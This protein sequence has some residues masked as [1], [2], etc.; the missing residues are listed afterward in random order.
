M[1]AL[2]AVYAKTAAGLEEVRHRALPLSRT[3]RT[4]LILV[5]GNRRLS[6]LAAALG[7]AGVDPLAAAE[8]LLSHRLIESASGAAPAAQSGAP[9]DVRAALVAA[10][11]DAFGTRAGPV[12]RKL[13]TVGSSQAELLA[14]AEA[15][16][17]LA[18]LTI[19][20]RQAAAFL[21]AARRLLA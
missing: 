15:A 7:G 3:E 6:A 14:G 13:E 10:A 1:A 21:D 9:R 8:A 5:D 17:K 19:D 2:E 18:K 12:L 20:E 11:Q 16:A 4:L